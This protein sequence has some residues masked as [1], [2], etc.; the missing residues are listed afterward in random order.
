MQHR[1]TVKA[2]CRVALVMA[3]L[4]KVVDGHIRIN[5]Y[6]L[7]Q[8]SDGDLVEIE[9]K[10][11][12]S[13]KARTLLQNSALHLYLKLLAEELNSAGYDMRKTMKPEAEIPWNM[14]NAKDFLWRP[15]QLALTEQEST[16]KL[17]RKQISEVYETLNRH[18]AQK[19]GVSVAWPD[20]KWRGYE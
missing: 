19:F 2:C 6:D 13:K 10:K 16:T 8:F 17:T 11:A 1:H 15:I 7:E 12:S 18:L 20:S 5:S 3:I 4:G 14:Q 9:V